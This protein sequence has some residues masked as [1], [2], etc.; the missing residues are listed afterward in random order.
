MDGY[1]KNETGNKDYSILERKLDKR[2]TQINYSQVAWFYNV[3]SKLTESKAAEMVL[4][5]SDLTDNEDIIEI[6]CG[7]GLV[8]KEMLKKNPNGRNL[9]IDLSSHMLAKAKKLMVREKLNN[10]ELRQGDVLHLHVE[11]GSFDKL[12]N[13]F[14]IDLM[15]K[16][17]FEF[18]FSEFNRILK[19]HGV[20]VISIFSF[21]QYRINKFWL[22]IA[23]YF[24]R[25]LTDC[26][27]V[28]IREDLISA[29]FKIE[30]EIEISQNTFPAKIYR[31]RKID[32]S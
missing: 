31:I 27:P 21:G 23:K 26:R 30:K 11:D 7:T 18:I 19:P 13:N 16:N 20:A 24:P 28:E 3:W 29:G 17:K 4:E 1:S 25:L 5:Y 32:K 10:Y 2:Q 8:F 6:A 14:M 12:I 15:P 22:A 9:G